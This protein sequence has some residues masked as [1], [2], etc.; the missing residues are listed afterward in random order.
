MKKIQNY[1]KKTQTK[2][3]KTKRPPPFKKDNKK[4]TTNHE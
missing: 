4:T 1:N 2:Q 3:N